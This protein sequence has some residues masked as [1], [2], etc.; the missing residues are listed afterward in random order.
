MANDVAQL[1]VIVGTATAINVVSSVQNK[2]D[3]VPPLVASGLMFTGLATFG[4]MSSK[5]RSRMFPLTASGI[6]ISR[7]SCGG[8]ST[9]SIL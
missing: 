8:T 9:T 6:W 7:R 1:A 4:E 3:A 2:R 5:W